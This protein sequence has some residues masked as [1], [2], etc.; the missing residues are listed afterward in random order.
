MRETPIV[1]GTGVPATLRWAALVLGAYGLVVVVNAT[2]L[3]ATND[4][5]GLA[6]YP[7]ALIR[8]LGAALVAWGLL[9]R[10]RWAWWLGV[11]LALFWLATSI[12]GF[13][14]FLGIR[15]PEAD[16]L[17]PPGFYALLATTCVLLGAAAALLLAPSS[18]AAVGRGAA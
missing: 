2:V 5:V 8:A 1:H 3:Q 7:R 13:L 9:R 6:E 18:R 11:V 14:M 15:T 16:A 10:A 4:W 12:F 17:L